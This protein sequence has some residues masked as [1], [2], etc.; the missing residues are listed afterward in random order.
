MT[1]VEIVLKLPGRR[2]IHKSIQ[3]KVESMK[4]KC[5]TKL[6]VGRSSCLRKERESWKFSWRTWAWYY[7]QLDRGKAAGTESILA[8]GAQWAVK[9]FEGRMASGPLG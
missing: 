6:K 3:S 2:E 1:Q 8:E 4:K 7:R 9:G 5:H